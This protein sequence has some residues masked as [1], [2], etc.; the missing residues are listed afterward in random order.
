M[1]CICCIYI[2]VYVC[3]SQWIV[4]HYF[5]FPQ[6]CRTVNGS[7]IS[8]FTLMHVGIKV[9]IDMSCVDLNKPH[10]GNTNCGFSLLIIY[11]IIIIIIMSSYVHLILML[12]AIGK[13]SFKLRVCGLSPCAHEWEQNPDQS[14]YI[15]NWRF[16]SPHGHVSAPEAR[17]NR[18]C[19]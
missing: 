12:R 17:E 6:L 5:M 2:W 16:A 15:H 19:A 8:H 13:I 14:V 1:S 11:S 10:T 3:I 4:F 9:R 18:E 7:M